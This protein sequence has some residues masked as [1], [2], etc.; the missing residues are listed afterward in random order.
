MH[1]LEANGDA[2]VETGLESM[3]TDEG[4]AGPERAFI[5]FVQV[6]KKIGGKRLVHYEM[7]S[8]LVIPK[9]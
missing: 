9:P 5:H 8:P 2:G 7:D 4:T 1:S 6:W 3:I